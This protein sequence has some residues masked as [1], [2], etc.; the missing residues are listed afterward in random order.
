MICS[1]PSLFLAVVNDCLTT[2]QGKESLSQRDSMNKSPREGVVS[3]E[4]RRVS[5]PGVQCRQ[6]RRPDASQFQLGNGSWQQAWAS[7]TWIQS[8]SRGLDGSLQ[9]AFQ[10]LLDPGSLGDEGRWLHCNQKLIVENRVGGNV[11]WVSGRVVGRNGKREA[12]RQARKNDAGIYDSVQQTECVNES[13]AA[14]QEEGNWLLLRGWQGKDASHLL[15]I[16]V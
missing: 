2:H 6:K 3:G 1:V 5:P 13:G 9:A 14:V 15:L 4:V 12:S 8:Q 7:H 11:R 16:K 10:R